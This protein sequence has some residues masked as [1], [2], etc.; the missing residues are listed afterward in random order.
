MLT[1]N[2]ESRVYYKA[3]TNI[4]Y[5]KSKME[6][7][8]RGYY[9]RFL[10][11]VNPKK[12]LDVMQNNHFLKMV[13]VKCFNAEEDARLVDHVYTKTF[14]ST[15]KLILHMQNFPI[16]P[17][18]VLLRHLAILA[19]NCPFANYVIVGLEK[20]INAGFAL[21]ERVGS[22]KES[23]HTAL[24]FT[25]IERHLSTIENVI[26]AAYLVQKISNVECICQSLKKI[27][28]FLVLVRYY[29]VHF[30]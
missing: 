9:K 18:P 8:Q 10:V 14:F 25:P 23:T 26:Y 7:L 4:I 11:E 24:T 3:K 20:L 27:S 30:S 6:H 19:N 22:V 15:K 5:T 2:S 17:L 28:Q 13:Y 1:I 21:L 16:F 12:G 29:D